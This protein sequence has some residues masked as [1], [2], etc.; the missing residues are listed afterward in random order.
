MALDVNGKNYDI[1]MDNAKKAQKALK[2]MLDNCN[3]DKQINIRLTEEQ[4]NLIE[5][6]MKILNFASI[7]EYL[8]FAA[9]NIKIEFKSVNKE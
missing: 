2:R 8:R 4:Y 3:K 7:S 6:H 1:T 5:S 9:L